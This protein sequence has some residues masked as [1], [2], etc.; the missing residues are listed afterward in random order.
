MHQ[1]SADSPKVYFGKG[2]SSHHHE[3]QMEYEQEGDQDVMNIFAQCSKSS[4]F[5]RSN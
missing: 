2:K 4:C 3:I 1:T 5:I